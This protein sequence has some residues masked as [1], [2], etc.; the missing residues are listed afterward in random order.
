MIFPNVP[1]VPGVPPLLRDPT[2]AALV[3]PALL[4]ADAAFSPET[5]IGPQWG[6]FDQNGN[7]VIVGDSCYGMSFRNEYRISNYPVEQGGFA[8]YNK[9]ANPYDFKITFTKGGTEGE[10][11]AFLL[12][13]ASIVTSLDLFE[14]VTPELRYGNANAVHY[15]Y[16]RTARD[17]ATLLI[18]D[19]YLEEVRQTATPTFTNTQ[20]P[21][22]S[23]A[24]N[25]G[26]VQTSTPA[27]T[28]VPATSTA[29]GFIQTPGSTLTNSVGN[30]PPASVSPVGSN[31][32]YEGNNGVQSGTVAS[33]N[34]KGYT[35]T[36][37]SFVGQNLVNSITPAGF[38]TVQ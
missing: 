16:R 10:R 29:P 25:N 28:S 19:V 27:Q 7:P 1:D 37:G 11:Q 17:G 9:V 6:I 20:A 36:D 30:S 22:G 18:V 23:G 12:A 8:S 15:D 31:I 13:V 26:N 4:I 3:L 34:S 35:L 33:M 14:A 38:K 32:I 24:V 5:V 2:A 21:D